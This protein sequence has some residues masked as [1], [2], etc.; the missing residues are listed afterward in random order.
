[1]FILDTNILLLLIRDGD[2]ARA[3][4]SVIRD[5][6]GEIRGSI[7]VVTVGEIRSLAR[8]LNWSNNKIERMDFWLAGFDII[9]IN[10]PDVFAQY[11]ELDFASRLCGRTMGKNDLWIAACAI[12][13]GSSLVTTDTDFDH[14]RADNFTITRIH[15][16]TGQSIST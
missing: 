10:H 5:T 16:K 1:V 15:P 3:I 6:S 14:L 4:R 12:A 7:S 13:T 2:P 11:V 9:D 8:Q